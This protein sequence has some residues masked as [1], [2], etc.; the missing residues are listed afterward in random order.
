VRTRIKCAS[1]K[2]RIPNS[3]PDYVPVDHA[4]GTKRFYH[5][6]CALAMAPVLKPGGVYSAFYRDVGSEMN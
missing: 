3:E 5:V 1:C 6:R 4:T 2:K